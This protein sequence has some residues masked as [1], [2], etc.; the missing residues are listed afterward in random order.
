MRLLVSAPSANEQLIS[1]VNEGYSALAEI[2]EKYQALKDGGNYDDDQADPLFGPMIE[3]WGHAVEQALRSIFPTELELNKFA[4]PEMPLGAVSGDYHYQSFHRRILFFIKGLDKIREQSVPQY[5]DLPAAHRLYVEDI[6][7]F[8]K[9]RDV[10]PSIVAPV[11]NKGYLDRPEDFVQ[12]GLEQILNVAFHKRD[13]GG[14]IN[15][16]YTANIIVN[17]KRTAAAFLLKGNGLKKN[18][19][20][21][22][23]CGANGDQLLRLLDSPAK[24]F[25]VQFVGNVSENV[26]RDIETKVELRRAR[27]DEV[28]FCIMDGQDSARVLRAYGLL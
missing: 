28:S 24:L 5:T 14:E 6:D 9:V 26:I 18:S 8:S 4:H 15:D 7:S 21:I 16:L 22:R 11:L 27:G 13:W 12:L 23:D 19:L 25:I 3:P 10:N 20:E 2:E 17:G 1:L